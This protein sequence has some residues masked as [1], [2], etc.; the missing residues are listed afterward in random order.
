MGLIDSSG[1]R[2]IFD[3]AKNLSDPINLSIGQ[4]DF[5]VPEP[6]K[7]AAC[8][9]IEQGHNRYTLT[10]GIPE[11]RERIKIH[12]EA[13]KH[14]SVEEVLITS[15]VSGGIFLS[16]IALLEA[17]DEIIVPDPYFV[18][19]K[20][21]TRLLGAT[22]VYLD[23]EEDFSLDPKKL[24]K[25]IT[26][27]TKALI[28][29]SPSNPTGTVIPKDTLREIAEI[30]RKWGI[31]IIS[32]EIYDGFVYEKDYE[33]IAKYYPDTLILAGFSKEYAMTGWRLGYAAG[34]A[35]LVNEMIKLQQYTF[36]CAPSMV[37]Y[38]GLAALDF[39]T[40]SFRKE[41]VAKRDIIYNGLKDKFQVTK[42]DGAFYIYPKAPGGSGTAFV[43]KAIEN[44]LLIIPGN[45]FSEHDTHFRISFAA[46]QETLYRGIEVLNRLAGQFCGG[47]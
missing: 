19:Y 30:A 15:G 34:P 12:I 33:S 18:M 43:T 17:G 36:V 25:L 20:H 39:D 3:L 4:P 8:K 24:E 47:K 23:L 7:Q 46:S 27:R 42:P 2:K 44:N 22:P 40:E 26:P 31:V 6:I 1:I 10:Q 32:D 35:K 16:F 21:L 38:A 37:Q 41:Y 28:L 9:A 11:L 5:D 13:K 14:A 29:N 45:V